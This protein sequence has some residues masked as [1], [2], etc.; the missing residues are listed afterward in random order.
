MELS[1][2]DGCVL[3]GARVVIPTKGRDK[4]LKLLH[5]YRH[6]KDKR[7]GKVV[8]VVARYGWEH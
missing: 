6:V 1:V 2:R 4:I 5:S 3:C 8:C 7:P